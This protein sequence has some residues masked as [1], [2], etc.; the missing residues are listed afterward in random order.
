MVPPLA[1]AAPT[2]EPDEPEDEDPCDGIP[3]DYVEAV[4]PT[5]LTSFADEKASELP[6]RDKGRS[7]GWHVKR[8]RNK[9]SSGSNSPSSGSNGEPQNN[10]DDKYWAWQH[11][12]AFPEGSPHG[13]TSFIHTPPD[14]TTNIYLRHNPS[15]AIKPPSFPEYC[16]SKV[17]V[18][19]WKPD[20][21]YLAQGV[22][23]LCPH[24]NQEAGHKCWGKIRRVCGL[25]TTW[26]LK[27]YV[28]ECR[29]NGEHMALDVC[30]LFVCW[31]LNESSA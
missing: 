27:S 22:K 9:P 25:N 29:C 6:A 15:A 14:P 30:V 26:F 20:A 5:L 24:C 1:A 21:Y 7:K 4:I 2:T 8:S 3:V 17:K 28:Y 16:L 19:I 18:C 31:S 10:S 11:G 12:E 13:W 23:V